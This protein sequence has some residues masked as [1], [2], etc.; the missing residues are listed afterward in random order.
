MLNRPCSR[1]ACSRPAAVTLTFDY[2]D[3]L[4]AIGPLAVEAEPHTYDLCTMHAD[5]LTA[6]QGWTIVRP[7]PIGYE[8]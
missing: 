3:R 8:G 2:E 6:P 4:A 7:V 5:R 1:V